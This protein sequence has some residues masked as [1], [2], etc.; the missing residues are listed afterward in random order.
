MS[1][2]P[3]FTEVG[4]PMLDIPIWFAFIGPAGIPRN[5]VKILSDGVARALQLKEVIDAL[6]KQGVEPNYGSPAE[7]DAFLKAEEV[8]WARLVKEAGIKPQ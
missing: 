7:L 4:Y 2:V 1:D 5:T 3:T 8:M 6:G